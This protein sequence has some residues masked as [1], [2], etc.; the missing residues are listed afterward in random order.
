MD[1]REILVS[2]MINLLE[3]IEC[4]SLVLKSDWLKLHPKI[5]KTIVKHCEYE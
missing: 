3:F 5:M 1:M 2:E 4:N